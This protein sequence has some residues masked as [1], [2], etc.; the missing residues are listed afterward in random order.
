MIEISKA[1]QHSFAPGKGNR[2]DNSKDCRCIIA[3]LAAGSMRG[4]A[5]DVWDN[6]T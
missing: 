3:H 4:N 2:V 6:T 1:E 5:F